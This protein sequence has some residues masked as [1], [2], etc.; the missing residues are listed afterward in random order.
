MYC[1]L[2][3]S[4]LCPVEFMASLMK[5]PLC[6][7][8]H[9]HFYDVLRSVWCCGLMWMVAC[10]CMS[11]FVWVHCTCLHECVRERDGE[12]APKHGVLFPSMECYFCADWPVLAGGRE[13]SHLNSWV[14][15]ECDEPHLYTH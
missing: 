3:K 11:L 13:G 4:F 9:S 6:Q 8:E 14:E 1:G 2:I 7:P 10:V 12:R 5:L 15:T